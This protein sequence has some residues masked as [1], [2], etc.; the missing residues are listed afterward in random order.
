MSISTR[1]QLKDLIHSIHGYIRNSGAGYGMK[2][3]RTFTLFYGLKLIE[4][5]FNKLGLENSCKFSELVKIANKKGLKSGEIYTAIRKILDSLAKIHNLNTYVYYE[6]PRDLQDE[7]YIHLIKEVERIPINSELDI[8]EEEDE[9]NLKIYDVDLK[10][11]IY[12]YFIGR[13]ATAIS[14]L[15]AY[16]TDRYI[17]NLIMDKVNPTLTKD[18]KV[19]TMIDPFGGSGGFT[20]TYIKYLNEHNENINWNT[21]LKNVYHYDM[22]IDAIKLAGLEMFALTGEFPVLRKNLKRTNTFREEFINDKNEIMHFDYI[23][24][25]PPY[26]G[27]TVVKDSDQIRRDKTINRL[28]K[29]IDEYKKDKTKKNILDKREKHLKKLNKE[30]KEWKDSKDKENVSYYTC[31][32]RIKS[33]VDNYNSKLKKT[34]ELNANDKE[35]CSL[36][37]FMDLLADN[38]TCIGVLKEG[39]FFD[40]TYSKIRNKLINNFEIT[41]L[42]SIPSDA[43]ENTTTKTSAII[44]KKSGNRTKEI[45]FSELVVEK[46]LEDI[47][48]DDDDIDEIELLKNEGDVINVYDRETARATYEELVKPSIVKNKKGEVERFD[49]SLDYKKYLKDET[50]CPEGYELK[51]LGDLCKFYTSKINSGDMDNNGVFNFYSGSAKNPV[52]K[53]SEYNFDFKQ[54]IGL[55]KG[56]GAG[57]GKYGDQIGLGKVF[58]LSGKNTLSNGMYVLLPNDDKYI[59]YIFNYL[60]YNKN[61]I[62]DLA[63]YTT[64]LGNIKQESLN[65]YQIPIP[66]DLTKLKPQLDKIQ[67][68][69]KQISDDTELIPQKEK[70]ICELIKKMTS[71]GKKGVDYEEH[72]IG[73]KYFNIINGKRIVKKN[74]IT[75]DIPVYGGGDVTFYTDKPNL[76]GINCLIS[77]YGNCEKGKCV[78]IIKGNIYL[79]DNG[80][81]VKSNSELISNYYLSYYLL[82]INDQI[83]NCKRG[84]AQLGF[85]MD[86][87]NNLIIKIPT[88]STMKKY[89]FEKLFNEVDQIKERLETTKK[90]HEKEVNLLMK[91]F[92]NK[93]QVKIQTK[94]EKI[95]DSDDDLDDYSDDES[96][97]EEKV[98]LKKT[99]K[100][101]PQKQSKN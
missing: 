71:E 50:Y 11:K 81:T 21:E 68:H 93:T 59:D 101:I 55:I 89:N 78:R 70:E 58:M 48:D 45:T 4:P 74:N 28:K 3:M 10:G 26:G 12:E 82:I 69:H 87:F 37:L 76:T 43:F 6:I 7:T 1:D 79:N 88:L 72:K 29:I 17:I 14:E 27:D 19:K 98:P 61:K 44:F 49:Y 85:D 83:F 18:K 9:D 86:A 57:E 35:A 54:Y 8:S 99:T 91:P 41:H 73:S 52:G 23:F 42:I 34:E 46:E 66:K 62:M 77:K 67:K 100:G 90:E 96:S 80:L 22:E 94:S 13:D 56:G 25:N 75:G 84:S 30:S 40:N 31:S 16:Y 53:H 63:T 15:G 33:W 24:T 64:G 97:E 20:L 32:K 60:S 95:I 2:A 47:F 65:N 38:G 92:E 51:K 5:N 36:I 39:L